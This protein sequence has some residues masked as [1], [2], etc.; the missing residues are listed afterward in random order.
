MLWPDAKRGG[1]VVQPSRLPHAFAACGV[2]VV[3]G[4]DTLRREGV[5]PAFLDAIATAHRAAV[6]QALVR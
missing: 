1:L 2:P 6:S 4:I 5:H 3:I